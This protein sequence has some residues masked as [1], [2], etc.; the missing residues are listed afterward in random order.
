M[1]FRKTQK[2][3]NN[4]ELAPLIDV[5]SFIVIYFLMNA[6]LEKNTALKVELPRSSSVA[7]EKQKDELV[8]TVDK[9]GKI[10]LDQNAEAVPLEG[11][12]EKINGFLGPEKERDPKKNK[13]II[14]GDGGAS[15]QVVVK[16]IDAVNAAGVSRFNLAMVKGTSK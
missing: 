9:Q 6:T 11:L 5:I 2:S 10:Y 8:I 14:R 4:I 7:K 16:V 3:F 1:K 15:Y 12:T 13:V